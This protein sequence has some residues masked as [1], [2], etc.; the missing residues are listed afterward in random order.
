MVNGLTSPEDPRAM[1]K[2]GPNTAEGARKYPA[3]RQG[4]T[5]GRVVFPL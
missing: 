4:P 5:K 3:S 2:W 1:L